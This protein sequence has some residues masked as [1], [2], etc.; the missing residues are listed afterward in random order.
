MKIACLEIHD[1]KFKKEVVAFLGYSFCMKEFGN[2]ILGMR[3]KPVHGV[4]NRKQTAQKIKA[5]TARAGVHMT[6]NLSIAILNS[7]IY[8]PNELIFLDNHIRT[9]RAICNEIFVITGN[10]RARFGEKVHVIEI[11]KRGYTENFSLFSRAASQIAN[12]VKLA[13]HLVKLSKVIDLTFFNVGEYRNILPLLV[14]KLLKKKSVVFHRSGDKSL[15]SRLENPRGFR[16]IIPPVQ[17]V[18][19]KIHYA[20]V[21]YIWCESPSIVTFGR[22]GRYSRKIMFWG[23]DYVDLEHFKIKVPPQER[24]LV[25][26]YAGR[27]SRKK[28][29][30]SLIDAVPI[31][32]EKCPETEFF[33]SGSGEEKDA[34]IEEI[35]KIDSDRVKFLAW[36]PEEEFPEFLNKLRVFVLPSLEEGIPGV[37][38]NAMACGVVVLATPVGGIPD[39]VTDGKTGLILAGVTPS[40]I[41]EGIVRALTNPCLDEIAL[42]GRTLVETESSFEASVDKW[43]ALLD[44]L[45]FKED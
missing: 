12:Q 18:L 28:C 8:S 16:I 5:P 9:L 32:L 11:E 33:I 24:G 25:V 45:L 43:K 14:S 10:Y 40:H 6:R 29:V 17:D 27:L 7:A 38:R 26:G 23:G 20:L 41:A 31:V 36:I 34:I 21:D 1:S 44:D 4:F 42:A 37:L 13:Y 39:L 2:Y 15:E 3:V 22:L 35:K 19:L 30:K